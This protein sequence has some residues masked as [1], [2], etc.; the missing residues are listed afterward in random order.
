MTSGAASLPSAGSDGAGADLPDLDR[1][2]VALRPAELPLPRPHG[3]REA[4][5]R[6]S[7]LIHAERRREARALAEEFRDRPA[8]PEDRCALLRAAL[9][10]ATITADPEQV[11]R[12]AADLVSVLH[13][14]GHVEQAAATAT[15]LLEREPTE[16][17]STAATRA[18][19]AE[20]AA[21][22]AAPRGRRRGNSP[23][24]SPEMLAV[25]R[26][27][28]L[29]SSAG[30]AR[31][32]D[33][34]RALG[35]LRAALSALPAVRERLLVDPEPELRL[36][37]AQ[38]LEALG[39]EAGA[40]TA[41]LDVLE[42]LEGRAA[43][44]PA[45][46]TPAAKT[47]AA[48]GLAGDPSSDPR[49][50]PSPDLPWDLPSSPAP[51]PART[52]TAARAVLARTLVAEHPVDA[53]HHAIDAL[54]TLHDVEDPPLRIGLITAL[55]QAL[56]TAGAT[57][58]AT[59]TA[60][61]LASLQRTLAR[62]AQRTAPLLAVA[63]QRLQ[64]ER[65]EAAMVPLEQA[66]RIAREHRDHRALLEAA[67]LGASIHERT[68]AG[69]ESLRELRRLAAEARWLADDLDTTAA[70]RAELIRT[71]LGANALVLRR[72]LDLG[73]LATVVEAAREIERRTRDDGGSPL[74]AELR[75]DHRVD[76]RVGLFIATGDALARGTVGVEEDAYEARR[77][78]AQQAVDEMPPG[79]DERARYWAAYLDDR[80]AHLLAERGRGTPA[81]KAARRARD[82]WAHLGMDEDAARVVALLETLQE[83]RHGSVRG[84]EPAQEG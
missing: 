34:R 46:E 35:P 17:R 30:T 67:R 29:S 20:A 43:G 79:H 82:G 73:R 66:R 40:T 56:M 37:L 52:E 65:F 58:H 8:P 83:R 5:A 45:A 1:L 13:R 9:Q 59:F 12:D 36:R 19:L 61:R 44:V 55:L 68:G 4:A 60:G 81:R 70:A 51:D 62:D 50:G 49:P 71:E 16:G 41:A 72:G 15:V 47:P 10:G 27:L 23:Q 77:R 2:R 3:V 42:L 25:V 24:V 63:A 21:P 18:A 7:D 78:E 6:V 31:G 54:D 26:A 38:T 28:A 48:D 69:E 76:A 80:H 33:P 22:R 57:R 14:S 32:S 11:R 75:W 74:P 39:D 84:S 53:A 64:A